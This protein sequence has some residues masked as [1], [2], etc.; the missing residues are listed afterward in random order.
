MSLPIT[1]LPDDQD[2]KMIGFM[3][4]LWT[5]FATFHNPTPN[6]K[7]WPAYG[8]NGQTYVRLDSSQILQKPD[9]VRDERLSFWHKILQ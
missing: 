8:I 6:D 5:N 7:S 9:P 4:D 3:V 1:T 2:Q